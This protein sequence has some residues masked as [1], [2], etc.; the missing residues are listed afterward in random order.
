V[1]VKRVEVSPAKIEEGVKEANMTAAG[2]ME[3][4]GNFGEGSRPS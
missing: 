3:A 4:A 2:A 1:A